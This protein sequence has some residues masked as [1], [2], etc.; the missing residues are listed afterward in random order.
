MELP[1]VV[2]NLSLSAGLSRYVMPTA[3]H[4][5]SRMIDSMHSV[6]IQ[7]RMPHRSASTSY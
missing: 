2:S 5:T 3:C 4:V 7:V 6:A 1:V